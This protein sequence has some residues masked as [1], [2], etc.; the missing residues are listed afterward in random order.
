FTAFCRT[1]HLEP[2]AESEHPTDSGVSAF[3][4]RNRQNGELGQFLMR[5]KTDPSL[6]GV[7]L[8]VEA[9]DRLSRQRPWEALSVIKEFI[10]AEVSIGDCM[11]YPFTG[12]TFCKVNS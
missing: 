8:V 11:T 3:R 1:H 9:Q 5:V 2:L 6:R 4:G 10:D 12:R 7:V